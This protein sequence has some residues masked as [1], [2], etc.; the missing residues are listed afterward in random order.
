MKFIHILFIFYLYYNKRIKFIMSLD[1]II[2]NKLLSFQVAHVYQLQECLNLRK[3]VI[4]A[5]DTGTGKTYCAI[6]TCALLKLTPFIICPKSVIANW[7][8]VCNEFG[9]KYL[10]I[11]NYEMLK[12]GNY[13]TENYE[14][15]KCPYM[16]IDAIEVTQ[17]IEKNDEKK[18][19]EIDT[20]DLSQPL[21][22]KKEPENAK[23]I[24]KR[25]HEYKFYLPK[26]TVT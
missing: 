11:S 13:Y 18:E 10:G 6:A 20:Q 2:T 12:N 7:S 4:D 1:E 21:K 8:N 9:V 19:K 24:K 17:E 3:K 26:D 15:V 23:Y 5:S 25:N 14:K 22:L 16:D